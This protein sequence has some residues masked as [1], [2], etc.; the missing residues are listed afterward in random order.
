LP[1]P[2]FRLYSEFSDDP[3]VQMLPEAMQR[4][5]VML[6]CSRCKGE[7]LQETQRAFHWRISMAELQE[8][9]ACFIE[10]GFMDDKWNVINWN[11]RQFLSDS[12]TDRVRKHRAALKQDETLQK[13][14]ETVTVTPSS[15]SV[16]VSVLPSGS[17]ISAHMIAKEV[18]AKLKMTNDEVFRQVAEQA[19]LDVGE[20]CEPEE[21]DALTDRMV[22]AWLSYIANIPKL[23]FIRKAQD[24][25][26]EGM[27]RDHA[28]WPWKKEHTNGH[29]SAR[30]AK[31]KAFL[32]SED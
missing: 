31:R 10:Q 19:R 20:G 18:L 1:N 5:L 17:G 21:A 27:W 24:F 7:T 25:Y 8:T 13:R 14:D 9:K 23:E 2:W 29:M 6:F 3:K 28:T 12:S 32:E 4:R 26:S 11:L 16:S 22:K 15:V 30:E